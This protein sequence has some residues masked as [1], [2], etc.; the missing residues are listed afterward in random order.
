MCCCSGEVLVCAALV[1]RFRCVQR[2]RDLGV[3]CSSREVQVCAALL[4]RFR[5][6]LL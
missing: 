4:E 1:E 2:W 5:Y 6:V 3:C